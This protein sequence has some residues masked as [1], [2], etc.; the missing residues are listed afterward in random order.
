MKAQKQKEEFALLL[1]AKPPVT[2]RRS[3][4]LYRS[5]FNEAIT[6]TKNWAAYFDTKLL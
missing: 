3:H 4:S 5:L 2:T 6:F 1:F